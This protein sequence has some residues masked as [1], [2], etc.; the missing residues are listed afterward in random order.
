MTITK[1]QVEAYQVRNGQ[2]WAN[3]TLRSWRVDTSRWGGEITI[4]SS[5]GTWG[6]FWNACGCPFKTFL[7]TS[8]FWYLFDK[9]MEGGVKRFDGALSFKELKRRVIE[10]RRRGTWQADRTRDVWDAFHAH[11][12]QIERSAEGFCEGIWFAVA[13]MPES[14]REEF[15]EPFWWTQTSDDSS[16]VQFWQRLWPEFKDTLLSEA[17]QEAL[18]PA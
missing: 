1:G 3:I 18:V 5:Y 9:F 13:D 15:A 6:H 17:K 16:A 4:L 10:L 12:D 8:D 14:V 11:R 2:E 7:A